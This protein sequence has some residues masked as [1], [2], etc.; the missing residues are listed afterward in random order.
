MFCIVF[1]VKCPRSPSKRGC[2]P[3]SRA[4][5]TKAFSSCAPRPFIANAS[6][7]TFCPESMRA[8]GKRLAR[9]WK[10][11]WASIRLPRLRVCRLR[12]TM[13][14]RPPSSK[15]PAPRVGPRR[16]PPPRAK[17][18]R[19]APGFPRSRIGRSV[20]NRLRATPVR[21]P[22]GHRRRF[23]QLECDRS[24][25]SEAQAPS[26]NPGEALA[27]GSGTAAL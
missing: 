21:F 18:P 6:A 24:P 4:D 5:W 15:S 25:R 27:R 19:P 7:A 2:N 26:P 8:F 3:C 17:R 9:A 16:P 11:R 22:R 12:E 13:N 14:H 23:P 1:K 10:L 20:S